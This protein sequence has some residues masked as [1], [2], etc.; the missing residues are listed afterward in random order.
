[1]VK[2]KSIVALIMA[3]GSGTRAGGGLPKQYQMLA[4]K[5]LLRHTMEAFLN[6]PSIK[7]TVPVINMEHQDLFRA[8]AG[9]LN[10]PYTIFGG[11]TRQESV[12]KAL[13][14]IQLLN[15]DYVLI[16]DAARP[17]IDSQ[18]ID[19]CIN[20]LSATNGIFVACPLQ[21]T[22]KKISAEKTA[23]NFAAGQSLYYADASGLSL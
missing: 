19:Q 23:G 22:L 1:M 15:A 13:L 18:L 5:P 20:K 16:H 4:G 8:A 6:H 7:Q 12:R 10:L 9:D 21:D 11:S 17:F 14:A 3:A 2:P